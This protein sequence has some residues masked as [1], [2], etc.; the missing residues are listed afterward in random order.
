MK[1]DALVAVP[2]AV[3]SVILPVVAPAGTV[4]VTRPSFTKAK[5][6]EAPLN[7]TPL[8]PVRWFPLIVTVAPIAPL[9]GEKLLMVGALLELTVK[10]AALVVVPDVVVSVIFPVVAPEGTVVAT[11]ASDWKLNVAEVPLNRTPLTPVKPLPVMVTAV[12]GGPVEGENP[13]IVGFIGTTKSMVLVPVPPDAVTTILPVV[14]P[15]GTVAVRCWS[16]ATLYV[17]PTPLNV[18]DDTPVPAVNPLP[19]TVTS[20]PGGPLVG[21]NDVTVVAAAAG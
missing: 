13:L 6:A 8:T 18:T 5:A 9:D 1:S 19:V 3:V 17:V 21:V 11:C 16:S 15:I 2:A 12:P 14:A 20:V 10:V 7:R 4:A